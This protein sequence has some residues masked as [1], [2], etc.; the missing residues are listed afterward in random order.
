MWNR[1]ASSYESEK[2]LG[3]QLKECF[4]KISQTIG[5]KSVTILAPFSCC[6]NQF[7]ETGLGFRM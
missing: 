6:K 4:F 1:K 3:V 7:G 5:I 2:V